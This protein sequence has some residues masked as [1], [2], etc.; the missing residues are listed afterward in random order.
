MD[1]L[2]KSNHVEYLSIS[3]FRFVYLLSECSAE[4]SFIM[5]E[6][7]K[8]LEEPT[9][10]NNYSKRWQ[11]RAAKWHLMPSSWYSSGTRRPDF[12][13]KGCPMICSHISNSVK[14]N[15]CKNRARK[16]KHRMQPQIVELT[17][18]EAA[19]FGLRMNF[20]IDKQWRVS[21]SAGR[22]SKGEGIHTR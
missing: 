8:V 3:E 22:H 7:E 11:F 4:T 5:S 17:L 16:S 9:G 1:A 12:E 18:R 10:K 2:R 6:R 19:P 14:T 13:A 20:Q 21:R 15:V